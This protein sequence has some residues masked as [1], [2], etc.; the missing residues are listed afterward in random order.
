MLGRTVCSD[1]WLPAVFGESS[2]PDG[3]RGRELASSYPLQRVRAFH[4]SGGSWDDRS[5][6]RL[7]RDTHDDHVPDEV[8]E[9]MKA[10]VP[11]CPNAETVVYERLGTSLLDTKNPSGFRLH[12]T[13]LGAEVVM[14][15]P[16]VDVGELGDRPHRHGAQAALRK[17]LGGRLDQRPLTRLAPSLSG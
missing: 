16:V 12:Q 6:R 2:A 11:M 3:H 14:H 8:L 5:D 1:L 13:G 15:E 10:I 17:Q 4:V 9:L 7:R